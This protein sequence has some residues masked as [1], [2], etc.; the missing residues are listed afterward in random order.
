MHY[1]E[2]TQTMWADVGS[3]MYGYV[4]KHLD[5]IPDAPNLGDEFAYNLYFMYAALQVDV[6]SLLGID[7]TILA[8]WWAQVTMIQ[9]DA[10][11]QSAA[12]L[13][14]KGSDTSRFEQVCIYISHLSQFTAK[15]TISVVRGKES[16]KGTCPVPYCR[17]CG[18]SVGQK[19]ESTSLSGA[20]LGFCYP[21]MHTI[22]TG[23]LFEPYFY[24][25]DA[26][27]DDRRAESQY[28]L[29]RLEAWIGLAN[30]RPM[31]LFKIGTEITRFQKWSLR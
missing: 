4:A 19:G 20:A 29:E 2:Y 7:P 18:T 16:H 15:E 14:G 17:V 1:P 6:A 31:S 30:G 13:G 26:D 22:A 28:F 24:H 21:L 3:A 23:Q 8:V 27:V 25:P 12:M 11:I 9:R 5:L 10:Y